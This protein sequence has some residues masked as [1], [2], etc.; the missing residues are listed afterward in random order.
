MKQGFFKECLFNRIERNEVTFKSFLEET[1][2]LIS[3]KR[4]NK[5]VTTFVVD[6]I[7]ELLD[8]ALFDSG[9]SSKQTDLSKRAMKIIEANNI[10]IIYAIS[11]STRIN[12]L[13]RKVLCRYEDDL[14]KDQ[15]DDNK[16]LSWDCTVSRFATILE[17]C[18]NKCPENI[19]NFRFIPK[20]FKFCDNAMVSSF[21]DL[22]VSSAREEVK[23]YLRLIKFQDTV[24]DIIT[25]WHN[26]ANN[27]ISID[28]ILSIYDIFIKYVSIMQADGCLPPSLIQFALE[29][30]PTDDR[31]ILA[32]QWK[33]ANE[34]ID[35]T[36]AN[37]FST[38]YMNA[39]STIKGE[40]DLSIDYDLEKEISYF[41]NNFQFFYKYQ[42]NAL[43]F[44]GSLFSCYP[45][46]ASQV[47]GKLLIQT[48]VNIYEEFSASSFALS[49]VC[50]LMLILIE[51]SDIQPYVIEIFIPVIIEKIKDEE[52]TN[53]LSILNKPA[54]LTADSIIENDSI[55]DDDEND[56][57]ISNDE[58]DS[59]MS[60]DDIKEIA[61]NAEN[62]DTA[63][64]IID[65][66]AKIID[67]NKKCSV[68]VNQRAFTLEFAKQ[69]IE[70]CSNNDE[71]KARLEEWQ[72]FLEVCLPV[73]RKISG[74]MS[75]DYGGMCIRPNI[76][77]YP[78]IDTFKPI[79]WNISVNNVI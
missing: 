53:F 66:S 13:A 50:T 28:G 58:N 7:D 21:F 5:I 39:L 74:I 16:H 8:Y 42:E 75:N 65:K 56:S 48:L 20:F 70:M 37:D 60:N 3:I 77:R 31:K 43:E 34:S 27:S 22:I 49:A 30:L 51:I 68:S 69:V 11:D 23:A 73:I 2:A 36:N 55:I 32:K 78:S 6:H 41:P 76:V 4:N 26:E 35:S 15:N 59:K 18:F 10:K 72:D 44:L 46:F 17:K 71:L 12:S 14:E 38:L 29:F 1:D 40:I 45:S 63:K 54:S 47:D 25:K 79:N 9:A 61:N 64:N 57:I 67:S 33:L 19:N 24:I 62:N 52:E